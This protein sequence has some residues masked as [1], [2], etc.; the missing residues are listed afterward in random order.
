MVCSDSSFSSLRSFLNEW[1]KY[2]IS[3]VQQS[4]VGFYFE[5][6]LRAPTCREFLVLH[7]RFLSTVT[8]LNVIF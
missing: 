8:Y 6:I 2:L 4:R 7:I 1:M 3:F 5:S